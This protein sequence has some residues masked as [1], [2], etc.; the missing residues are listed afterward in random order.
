MPGEFQFWRWSGGS[1][2]KDEAKVANATGCIH[3]RKAV[4]A[5][6][7]KDQR[8]DIFVVCYGYDKP[9]FPGEASHVLLSQPGGVYTSKAVGQAGFYHGATA[10]DIKND[11]NIDVVVT[12][13]F[14]PKAVFAFVNDG[15]GTFTAR[16]DLL[17]IGAGTY[18]TVEA[19]DVDGDG[20]ID[21]LAGGHDWEGAETVV[22]INNGSGSFAGVTPQVLPR[23]Q[24]EGVV[25][26]F[27]VLDADRDGVNEIYVL[28]TSGGDGTFYQSRTVQK[29]QWPSLAS[30]Y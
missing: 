3:P 7:N 1:Y 29:V 8:P 25:L 21:L 18:F 27:V 15:Q 23:V 30:Q 2:V 22:L 20:R 5:D 17:P 10:L 16:T 11:G 9:P 28:R 24:N 6:F 4:V 26:D 13:N 19:A 12:N 14:A